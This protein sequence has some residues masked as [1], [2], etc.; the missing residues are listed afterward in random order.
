MKSKLTPGLGSHWHQRYHDDDD[1]D[2]DDCDDDD[3]E[4]GEYDDDDDDEKQENSHLFIPRS[5]LPRTSPPPCSKPDNPCR[6]RFSKNF[7]NFLIPRI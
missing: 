3:D 7:V 5:K 1:D 4:N 2:D 6:L